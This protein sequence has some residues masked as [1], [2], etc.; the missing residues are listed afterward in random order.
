LACVM[1]FL[2]NHPRRQLQD[3]IGRWVRGI[4]E[5]DGQTTVSGPGR[6]NQQIASLLQMLPPLPDHC[7]F[8]SYRRAD[9]EH[10]VGRLYEHLTSNFGPN[11]IFKDVDS[12]VHGHDFRIQLEASLNACLV[13][14]CV[15]GDQWAGPPDAHP[16]SIDN[17]DD[18]VRIEVETALRRKIPLIPVFVRG[19]RMP[20]ADYFPPSLKDLAF[21]L[22]MPLRPDPD[23]GIDVARLMKSITGLLDKQLGAV[24]PP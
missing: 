16:R 17:S 18:F 4:R 14:V 12:L 23:F 20:A 19:L 9:S 13:F 8:I 3:A 5:I 11:A 15:M 7:V 10:V 1:F 6:E 2:T 21:Q 24:K 22:G